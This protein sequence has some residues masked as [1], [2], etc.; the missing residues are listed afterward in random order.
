MDFPARNIFLAPPL[1]SIKD[2]VVIADQLVKKEFIN[3]QIGHNGV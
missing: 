3:L 1:N 2:Q